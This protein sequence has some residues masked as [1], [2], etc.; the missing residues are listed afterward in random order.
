MSADGFGVFGAAVLALAAAPILIGGAAITGTVYGSVKLT[1]HIAQQRRKSNTLREQREAEQRARLAE[2]EAEERERIQEIMQSYS[3]LQSNQRAAMNRIN[4]QMLRSYTSFANEM[5]KE[6][7]KA[8]QDISRLANN[9]AIRKKEL[10]TSWKK[11]IDV[12]AK[13]YADSLH[14]T[15]GTMKAEVNH[16]ISKFNEMKTQLQE[17]MRLQE[18]ASSQLKDAEAA[19][20]AVQI[21]LGSIPNNTVE[22]Y[23][24]AA[25]YFNKGMYEPAYGIASSIVLECYDY[26]EEGISDREKKYALIDLLEA[27]IVEMKAQIESM[28]AFQFE[29]KDEMYETDLSMYEPVFKAVISRLEKL[30]AAISDI[31]GKTLRDFADIQEQLADIELDI[32]NCTKLAVQ[33]LLSAYT[34]ND[35][36]SDITA[37]MEDQGYAAFVQKK[38]KLEAEKKKI[39]EQ[40]KLKEAK[41]ALN[42]ELNEISDTVEG[43]LY[44]HLYLGAIMVKEACR[45]CMVNETSQN[46]QLLIHMILSHHG[47]MEYGAV[48]SPATREAYVLH[49]LD[50]LDSKLWVYEDVMKNTEPGTFSQPNR[51]L[52]GAVVYNSDVDLNSH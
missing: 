43:N 34:E 46:I 47:K 31:D 5:Q 4:E 52:D 51:W 35:T 6:Q 19:I 30:D 1:K 50:E 14:T 48:K 23:N 12:Q 20:H 44:G 38:E 27:Q 36:A 15:F 40:E 7:N 37:A 2:Q 10:F 32:Q 41:A 3:S 17:N 42:D 26:L 22:E 28:K 11:E 39:K 13:S 45:A 21:E 24:K 18:Y 49:I 9:A 16:Q 8:D 33:K 25:D 29:Y